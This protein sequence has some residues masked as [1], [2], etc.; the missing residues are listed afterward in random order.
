ML[1]EPPAR[2]AWTLPH[3]VKPF[4]FL[5]NFPFFFIINSFFFSLFFFSFL[6]FFFVFHI[7]SIVFLFSPFV[8]LCPQLCSFFF[9]PFSFFYIFLFF[10]FF[11]LFSF[12]FVFFRFCKTFFFSFFSLSFSFPFLGCSKSDFLAKISF[13]FLITFCFF[14]KKKI[15]FSARLGGEGVPLPVHLQCAALLPSVVESSSVVCPRCSTQSPASVDFTRFQHLCCV[16]NVEVPVRDCTLCAEPQT[17]A[18]SVALPC[19][20]QRM[21]YRCLVLSVHACGDGCPFCTRDL[22]P[23]LTDPFVATS[24]A[25]HNLSLDLQRAPSNSLVNSLHG[26]NLPPEPDIWPLCCFRTSGPPDFAPVDDR[27]MEWSRCNPHLKGGPQS[28]RLNGS[29]AL[30]GAPL[31]WTTSPRWT[32]F[33]ALLAPLPQ[34][35]CSTDQ[36]EGLFVS[37]SPVAEKSTSHHH[38]TCHFLMTSTHHLYP[39]IPLLLPSHRPLH[40][41]HA[42]GSPTVPSAD[43]AHCTDGDQ[44]LPRRPEVVAIL[45]FLPFD[46]AW[47]GP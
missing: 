17:M 23:F 45:A 26:R 25:H 34:V 1:P 47:V 33:R 6:P 21:H 22:L 32:W 8:S 38:P 27:R 40:L 2:G 29:A 30:V 7:F 16:H 28:G 10:F 42:I 43:S 5:S 4:F 44:P 11:F 12:V 46:L 24:L 37:V 20:H 9:H 39:T 13:R 35:L 36:L 19:C 14:F 31:P 3:S 15:N 41:R 18:N